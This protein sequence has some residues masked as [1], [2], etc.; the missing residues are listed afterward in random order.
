VKVWRATEGAVVRPGVGSGDLAPL[1]EVGGAA[2]SDLPST[3]EGSSPHFARA[4]LVLQR[5]PGASPGGASV[6]GHATVPR[7]W[8][9]GMVN[10]VERSSSQRSASTISQS[11]TT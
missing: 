8:G 6:S 11:A 9:A 1:G 2:P 10:T 3:I 5:R 7:N 4:G